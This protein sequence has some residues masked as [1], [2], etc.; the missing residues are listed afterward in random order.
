M[1]YKAD[2]YQIPT[3]IDATVADHIIKTSHLLGTERMRSRIGSTETGE[4]NKELRNSIHR[5]LATDC[6]IAG[7]M[8]HYINEANR[9]FFNFDLEG[10][11]DSIQYTEYKGKN[12]HYAWHY[13]SSDAAFVSG[14]VRKLSISLLLSDPEDYEGGELQLLHPGE[15]RMVTFKPNLG[16][17]IIFPSYL[18]HR[19]R[20]LKSGNR[21]SLVGWYGGPPFR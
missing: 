8:A 4:V 7:M 18:Q 2:Y 20:P 14:G 5:W 16:Q 19:V 17:A 10:W 13:D 1:T 21:F 3:G 6:W 11:A 9:N 12:T 15:K